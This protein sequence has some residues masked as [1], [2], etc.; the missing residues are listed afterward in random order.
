MRQRPPETVA[1]RSATS[2]LPTLLLVALALGGV[3]FLAYATA[4]AAAGGLGWGY[5]FS[6]Y[7][8]AAIRLAATG[9][10]YQ[11][12]TL[13]GPFRPG[14]ADLYLYGPIPA[15]LVSPLTV[16]SEAQAAPVWA[17]LRGIL[18]VLTCALMPVSRNVRLATLGVAGLSE[19]IIHDLILGNVSLVVTFCSVVLWRWLDRPLGSASLAFSLLIRPTMAIVDVWWLLR[20]QWRPVVWT[21]VALIVLFV[22]S[23]PFVG[24]G[25]WFDY[26]TLLRN[27]TG[28]TGVP[29]NVDLA[30]AAL[31]LGLPDWAVTGAL[32]VG[33]ALAAVAVV[34][35]LRRDTELSFIVT[36][37]ASLLLSPLLWDH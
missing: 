17:A 25:S 33:Y 30:S 15:L 26:V 2:W 6:A 12:E 35:S 29:A 31:S 16:F 37:S 32:F 23:L 8:D 7:Y 14:P 11:P 5:D 13:S 10:P 28:L 9:S 34:L 21:G 20:R 22:V 3:C 24:L 4:M 1:R 36:I 18:L 19:P 27:L